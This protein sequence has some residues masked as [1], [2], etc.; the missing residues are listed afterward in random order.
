MGA[1]LSRTFSP[2]AAKVMISNTN[3]ARLKLALNGYIKAVNESKNNKTENKLIAMMNNTLPGLTNSHKKRITNA[4]ASIVAKSRGVAIKAAN[5]AAGAAPVGPA[6]AAVNKLSN[7]IVNLN[8]FMNA[9]PKNANGKINIKAYENAVRKGIRNVKKNRT[10]NL[11][12]PVPPGVTG[13]TPLYK[14]ILNSINN[15]LQSVN[16]QATNN[17]T[18]QNIF[19]RADAV[20]EQTPNA[21]VN[22]IIRQLENSKKLTTNQAMRTQINGR[23]SKLSRGA[24][25]KA[26]PNVRKGQV[27]GVT[28][29]VYFHKNLKNGYFIKNQNGYYKKLPNGNANVG[30]WP[31]PINNRKYEFNRN[32]G[33]EVIGTNTTN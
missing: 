20:T 2:G 12:R 31:N 21:N 32:D 26:P 14:N 16:K 3:S 9:L 8:A 33:F 10:T 23:I 15:K 27:G 29:N 4:I 11:S 24:L 19:T 1:A 7:D 18:I 25:F 13:P 6:V 22:A 5:A 28:R 30:T 17:A